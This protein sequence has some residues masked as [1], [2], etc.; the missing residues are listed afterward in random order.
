MGRAPFVTFVRNAHVIWSMRME[1]S[2]LVEPA[3]LWS[4]EFLWHNP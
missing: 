2:G 4:M 3:V 1:V